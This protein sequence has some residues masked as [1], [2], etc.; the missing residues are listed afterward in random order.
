MKIIKIGSYEFYD[1][2]DENNAHLETWQI[3]T[4]DGSSMVVTSDKIIGTSE[5]T[6]P[7][8]VLSQVNRG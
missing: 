6:R 5:A 2:E 4:A 7:K 3:E 8:P 1:Y